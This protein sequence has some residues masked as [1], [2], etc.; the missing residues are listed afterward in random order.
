MTEITTHELPQILQNLFLEV[1][2]TKTPI[3]VI[4]EGK[5][6]VIIYPATPSDE[7][8]AFGVMKGS[9]EILGDIITP[10]PQPWD[11]LQ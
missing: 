1:E 8:P 9:G 2:R 7:R 5:P 11:V 6:L 10:D 4:H 3:T